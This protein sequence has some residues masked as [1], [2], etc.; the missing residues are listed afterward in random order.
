MSSFKIQKAVDLGPQFVD[1]PHRMVGQDGAFSIPLG[2]RK[3][4]WFF[5]D[6]LIGSRVPGSSLWYISGIA[7]GAEDMSGKGTID[8]MLNNTGLILPDQDASDGLKNFK[9]IQNSDGSLKTLLPLL[10]NEDPNEI[11]VWCQHGV[12]IGDKLYLSFVKVRMIP[13]SQV[14]GTNEK[15]EVFPVNFDVIGSGL[16]VGS[17][18][19][20]EFKR[21]FY[22]GSDIL[23]KKHEPHFGSAIFPV[24]S[25]RKL[26]L[27]GTHQGEDQIQ[28][29]CLARVDFDQIEQLDKYEYLVSEKPEWSPKIEDSIVLFTDAPSEVSI[30]YNQHLGAYLAV[31]SWRTTSRI[32]GH[33]AP[34]LWGHW[35]PATDLWEAQV[36]NGKHLPYPRLIYAGKEHPE[37]AA[38]NGKTILLTYI[39]FEEYYPHLVR[40]T[41][42]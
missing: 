34:A 31:H 16:A 15:G 17:D 18:K 24:H 32:V 30:S 10:E 9:Y 7:V 4:L 42:N 13:Q 37:L 26:Y 39:E 25:E 36:N 29:C 12:K 27:Y 35:S 5:G 28:K 23:W 40:I 41:F 22:N 6:T 14:V 11:R 20:W 33:I 8:K 2:N 38:E 19:T 3:S 21:I 1:N